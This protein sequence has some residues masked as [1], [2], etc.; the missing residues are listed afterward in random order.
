MNTRKYFAGMALSGA[1]LVQK[2]PKL[3]KASYEENIK[4][5]AVAARDLAD[6]LIISLKE[7]PLDKQYEDEDKGGF[8]STESLRDSLIHGEEKTNFVDPGSLRDSL[9][10]GEEKT[11]FVDPGSLQ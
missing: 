9:I 3:D 11:N 2:D 10:H 8:V 7:K 4:N 5:C 1:A 6:A